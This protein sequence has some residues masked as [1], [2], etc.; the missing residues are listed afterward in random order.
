MLIGAEMLKTKT[1]LSDTC[2]IFASTVPTDIGPFGLMLKDIAQVARDAGPKGGPAERSRR[3][4]ARQHGACG[5]PIKKI[6]ESNLWTPGA[7]RLHLSCRFVPSSTS[8]HPH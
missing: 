8:C 2:S 6:D 3:D 7:E 1:Q 4:T 5:L